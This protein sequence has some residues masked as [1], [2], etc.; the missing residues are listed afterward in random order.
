MNLKLLVT[1]MIFLIVVISIAVGISTKNNIQPNT[2]GAKL[3]GYPAENW[4]KIEIFRAPS[5]EIFI[6]S[7]PLISNENE[8]QAFKQK[9]IERLNGLQEGVVYHNVVV[10]F[11]KELNEEE[12]NELSEIINILRLKYIADP[13]GTGTIGFPLEEEEREYLA[14]LEQ[15]IKTKMSD[16]SNLDKKLSPLETSEREIKKKELLEQCDAYK[17]FKLVKG[18]VAADVVDSKENL[19]ELANHQN[20]LF[21]DV[22]PIELL[23]RYPNAFIKPIKDG[24]Y[25][26]SKIVNNEIS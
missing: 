5:G 13:E 18:F 22:G 26:Y 21:V 20:V 6:S 16:C 23:E 10:T 1:G 9:S 25:E 11:S 19:L 7:F 24:W 2:S 8:I 15:A 4:E 17:D 12:V 3:N 14:N